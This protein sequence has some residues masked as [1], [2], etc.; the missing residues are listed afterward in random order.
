VYD[1]RTNKIFVSVAGDSYDGH[2]NAMLL[3]QFGDHH[4]DLVTRERHILNC[5]EE[6]F[7]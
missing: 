7:V 2:L 6:E 3:D 5:V 1:L 4:V